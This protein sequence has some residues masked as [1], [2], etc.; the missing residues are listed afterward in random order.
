MY[1]NL[2]AEMSKKRMTQGD[3]AKVLNRSSKA[4]CLKLNGKTD[5]TITEIKIL[6]KIFDC[7]F[8]YLFEEI[9]SE[10]TA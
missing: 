7:T 9:Q 8:E 3:I 6:C 1:I 5:F 2:Y 4:V 10:K